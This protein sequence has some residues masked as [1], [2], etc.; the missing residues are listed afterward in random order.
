M[1]TRRCL[2]CAFCSAVPYDQ[3]QLLAA[4]QQLQQQAAAVAVHQQQQQQLLAQT[5]QSQPV[6]G[7]TPAPGVLTGPLPATPSQGDVD[8]ANAEAVVAPIVIHNP[9]EPVSTDRLDAIVFTSS[10]HWQILKLSK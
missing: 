10:T 1:L 4:Q 5:Q 3:Q 2:A 8:M 7:H 9:K 6:A